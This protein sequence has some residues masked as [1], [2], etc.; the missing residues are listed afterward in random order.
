MSTTT[1]ELDVVLLL[2]ACNAALGD[3]VLE[4]SRERA[5]PQVRFNDGYV[6]QHLVPGPLPVGELAQRQGVSQQATSQQVADLERRGLVRRRADPTDARRRLVE[7]SPRGRRAVEG[8]R[9]ARAEIVAELTGVLGERRMAALVAGLGAVSD[10]T[11][12]LARL[13]SRSLRPEADR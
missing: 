12:A 2:Q 3:R 5:G 8:A 10:H 4:R 7:L 6:F 13:A 11:G 1:P 9:E